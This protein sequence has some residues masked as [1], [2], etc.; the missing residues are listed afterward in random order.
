MR[1]YTFRYIEGTSGPFKTIDAKDDPDF[2]KQLQE[3]LGNNRQ[4]MRGTIR[5]SE[6]GRVNDPPQQAAA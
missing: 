2:Y 5:Y 1:S 3:F 4:L 6:H